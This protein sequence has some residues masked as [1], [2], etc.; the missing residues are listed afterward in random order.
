LAVL[1][2]KQGGDFTYST[3]WQFYV[4]HRVEILHI[5]RCCNSTYNTVLIIYV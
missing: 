5:T 3:E 4:L 1:R 2:L